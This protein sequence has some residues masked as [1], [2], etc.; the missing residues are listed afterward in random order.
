MSEQFG[1]PKPP[2]RRATLDSSLCDTQALCGLG[3]TETL[4]IEGDDHGALLCRQLV[5]SC[6]DAHRQVDCSVSVLPTGHRRD[7]ELGKRNRG[8]QLISPY[9]VQTCVDDD[10][11]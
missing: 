11:M 2:S 8:A 7:V 5:Q 4:D 10:A 3:D 6:S 9:P 1:Q